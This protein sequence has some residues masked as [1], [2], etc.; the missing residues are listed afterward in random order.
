MLGYFFPGF[1]LHPGLILVGLV[2]AALAGLAQWRVTR[3]FSR[4]K[5]VGVRSGMT[6]AEAAR[7]VCRARGVHD[8]TIERHAGFLSDHY[9][10][11]ARA[12]RLSPDVHDGRSVSSIAVAAHEAG[13]AIQH[14]DAYPMLNFRSKMVP[15]AILGSN[16]WYVLFIAGMLLGAGAQAGVVGNALVWAAIGTFSL[17]VAFQLV[18]LPVEFDASRRAKLVLAESGIVTSPE[19]ARGVETVLG[20]AAMTYVAA[21]AA[22]ILQLLYLLSIVMGSQRRDE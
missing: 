21:A 11:K 7:A 19:E 17:T 15:A 14:A 10:P 3:A 18:T 9:D 2:G 13:H 8:V 6:G 12:L 4:Y 16:L 20:A 22:S 1:Y 5:R